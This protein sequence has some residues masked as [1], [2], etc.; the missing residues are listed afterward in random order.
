MIS[1]KLVQLINKP[2]V[3]ATHVGS[4]ADSENA[5]RT[6]A[7]YT[8]EANTHVYQPA[9]Q[10]YHHKFLGIINDS[11][12]A[13]GCLVAPFGYGKT[14]AAVGIWHACA[15]HGILAVPPFS[16]NSI[17]KWVKQSPAA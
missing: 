5:A 15:Q 7:R 3:V 16:C 1:E 14:S 17:A 8:A 4:F 2:P 6:L 11:N 10:Q 9:L 12:T 13:I